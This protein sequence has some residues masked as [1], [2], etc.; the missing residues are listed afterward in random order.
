M[1]ERVCV[2]CYI[3]KFFCIETNYHV[4]AYRVAMEKI[5]KIWLIN[6]LQF[7][8]TTCSSSSGV[9]VKRFRATLSTIGSLSLIKGY[10]ESDR[11][12]EESIASE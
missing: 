7:L 10:P 12:R 6:N 3:R 5:R 8:S 2:G 9:N 11:N 1:H 4:G